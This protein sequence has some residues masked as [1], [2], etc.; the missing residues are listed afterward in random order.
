MSETGFEERSYDRAHACVYEL[1]YRSLPLWYMQG[2]PRIHD[3]PCGTG[4]GRSSFGSAEWHGLD[5]DLDALSLARETYPTATFIQGDMTEL[6]W[7]DETADVTL[8]I[9]GIEHVN[10]DSK[11]MRELA[12]TTKRGGYV[13]LSTP[14]RRPPHLQSPYHVREYTQA[15]FAQLIDDAGLK[16]IAW[17]RRGEGYVKHGHTMIVVCQRS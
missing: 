2:S 16:I 17:E 7:A 13:A 15:S 10:A 11:A 5:R 6:P 3:V 9:E 14:E 1:V 4:Y 8:C 12:R